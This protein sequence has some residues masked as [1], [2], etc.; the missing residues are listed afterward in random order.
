[1]LELTVAKPQDFVNKRS[2]DGV[3][4]VTI[5]KDLFNFRAAW[6]LAVP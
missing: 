6:N 1:L 3:W 4:P 5:K 2:K